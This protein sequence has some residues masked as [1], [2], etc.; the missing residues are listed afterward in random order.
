MK[1][2]AVTPET[3]QQLFFHN[4]ARLPIAVSHGEGVWLYSND[5]T[6][7]LD[8]ISGIGVNAL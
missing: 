1:Q 3:E 5:G 8:M 2:T 6:R 4:Y 7:Y